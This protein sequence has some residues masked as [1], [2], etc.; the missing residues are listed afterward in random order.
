MNK[1]FAIFGIPQECL[2]RLIE[3]RDTLNP[4]RMIAWFDFRGAILQEQVMRSME[5]LSSKVLPY[6]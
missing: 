1:G 6:V 5:L 2:E 4:G 3:L